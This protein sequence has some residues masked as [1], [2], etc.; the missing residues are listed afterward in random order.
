MTLSRENEGM[1]PKDLIRDR[2]EELGRRIESGEPM[3]CPELVHGTLAL[4]KRLLAHILC[5]EEERNR[6]LAYMKLKRIHFQ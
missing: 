2:I 5:K 4:N 6:K 3:R 1:N